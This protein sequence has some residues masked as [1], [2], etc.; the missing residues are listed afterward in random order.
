VREQVKSV[1]GRIDELTG[2]ARAQSR[3]ALDDLTDSIEE[4]PLASVLIAFGVGMLIGRLL[5]R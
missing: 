3:Q 4:R 1:R 5:D 2:D